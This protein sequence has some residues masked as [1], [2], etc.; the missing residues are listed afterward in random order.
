MLVAKGTAQA[1]HGIHQVA[2]GDTWQG[3]GNILLGTI[4]GIA[5]GTLK[6]SSGGVFPAAERVAQ[7]EEI[8]SQIVNRGGKL[9]P[10]ETTLSAQVA[11]STRSLWQATTRPRWQASPNWESMYKA[12]IVPKMEGAATQWRA[13]STGASTATNSLLSNSGGQANIATGAYLKRDLAAQSGIPLP[14][15]DKVHHVGDFRKA[16]MAAKEAGDLNA[17]KE[18]LTLV[19]GAQRSPNRLSQ[20]AVVEIKVNRIKTAQDA[21]RDTVND[22]E[23]VVTYRGRAAE[24]ERALAEALERFAD[25]GQKV[26]SLNPSDHVRKGIDQLNRIKATER[27]IRNSTMPDKQVLLDRLKNMRE[28]LEPALRR[29]MEVQ[30]S[31]RNK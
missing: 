5:P 11:P 19:S 6:Y 15:A 22:I 27:R 7:Q 21:L 17:A 13:P 29:A 18:L 26:G 1:G 31:L 28:D 23:R 30:N 10:A 8:I 12:N 25:T 14:Q 9:L 24:G 4:G 2:E 20:L 16:Y 3:V